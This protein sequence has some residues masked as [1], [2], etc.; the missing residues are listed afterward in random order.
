M[1]SPFEAAHEERPDR[2]EEQDQDAPTA[3]EV[4]ERVKLRGGEEVG[5]EGCG[6]RPYRE[7]IA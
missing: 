2:R 4:H 1:H 6:V 3:Q 5:E 7:G